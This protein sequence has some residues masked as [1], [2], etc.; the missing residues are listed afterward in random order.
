MLLSINILACQPGDLAG[1]TVEANARILLDLLE[2]KETGPR[3]DVALL[4]AAAVIYVSGV[5]DSL[6]ESLESARESLSSGKA[7]VKLEALRKLSNA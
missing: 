1:D 3:R 5:V 7:Q 2:G 6:A 4:N